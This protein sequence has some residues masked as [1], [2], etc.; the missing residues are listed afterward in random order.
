MLKSNDQSKILCVY[1]IKKPSTT[2]SNIINI[3]IVYA[4]SYIKQDET[5]KSIYKL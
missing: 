4:T 1:I 3:V 5:F 2:T